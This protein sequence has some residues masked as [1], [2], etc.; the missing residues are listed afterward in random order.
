M[1]KFHESI[2]RSHLDVTNEQRSIPRPKSLLKYMPLVVFVDIL[3][4]SFDV[5]NFTGRTVVL[6]CP[7]KK[8]VRLVA[9]IGSLIGVLCIYISTRYT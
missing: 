9:D 3:F 8:R 4:T 2:R 5:V 1:D 6:A 7:N